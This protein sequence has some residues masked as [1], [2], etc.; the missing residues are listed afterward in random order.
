ML[1]DAIKYMACPD[2]TGSLKKVDLDGR[3]ALCC[4]PCKTVLPVIDGIV[5]ALQRHARNKKL[6][7]G[8]LEALRDSAVNHEL[9]DS[10]INTLK[11]L[12]DVDLSQVHAWEDEAHWSEVYE[13]QRGQ[14]LQKNW[15]DRMLRTRCC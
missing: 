6:E 9:H 8:A 10:C 1:D 14:S 11:L 3:Q 12:E 2:C 13:A 4:A 15:N 7:V 5:F